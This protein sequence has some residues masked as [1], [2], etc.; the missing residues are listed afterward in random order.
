MGKK[1]TLSRG[2]QISFGILVISIAAWSGFSFGFGERLLVCWVMMTPLLALALLMLYAEQGRT[3]R[4]RLV[5]Q[6]TGE[7]MAH[8]EAVM[9]QVRESNRRYLDMRSAIIAQRNDSNN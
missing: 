1:N 8:Y 6:R 7:A 2:S 3:E 5:R 9:V 4:Y